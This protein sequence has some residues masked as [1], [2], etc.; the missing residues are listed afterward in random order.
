MHCDHTVHVSAELSLWLDSPMLWAVGTGHPDTIPKHVVI[1]EPTSSPSRPFHFHLEE[2]WGMH[3]QTR[4][5]FK[6]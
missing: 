4:R 5:R 2:R 6:R 1:R 3:V